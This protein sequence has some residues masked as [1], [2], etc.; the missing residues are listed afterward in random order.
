[1]AGQALLAEVTPHR[2]VRGAPGRVCYV[3]RHDAECGGPASAR[4]RGRGSKSWLLTTAS[5]ASHPAPAD[6]RSASGAPAAAAAYVE[7]P[8]RRMLCEVSLRHE[9]HRRFRWDENAAAEQVACREVERWPAN[10]ARDSLRLT[11]GKTIA[12]SDESPVSSC[13]TVSSECRNN[14][15]CFRPD[16]L[17]RHCRSPL[18]VSP[19]LWATKLQHESVITIIH[20][21]MSDLVC[22]LLVLAWIASYNGSFSGVTAGAFPENVHLVTL[23]AWGCG[24]V[25]LRLAHLYDKRDAD[26]GAPVNLVGNATESAHW[27]AP[28]VFVGWFQFATY[29]NNSL[30]VS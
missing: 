4:R 13:S 14:K 27:G 6:C 24:S 23:H 5:D 21:H 17:C 19:Y 26:L 10:A 2:G 15:R 3:H 25:L 29:A 12:T 20:T 16:S 8:E 9:W 7:P 18:R 11:S 1:M 30:T 28:F 22:P